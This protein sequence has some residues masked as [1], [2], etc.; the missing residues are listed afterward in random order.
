MSQVRREHDKID[1][2]THEHSTAPPKPLCERKSQVPRS[3]SF[4]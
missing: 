3:G 1:T 2:G 4:R